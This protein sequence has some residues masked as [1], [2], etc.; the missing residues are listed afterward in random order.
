MKPLGAWRCASSI[1]RTGCR[2][3][4]VVGPIEAEVRWEDG[5]HDKEM[6]GW[7]YEVYGT[8]VSEQEP[9]KTADAA[10]LAAEETLTR[11]IGDAVREGSRL[12]LYGKKR[13][14][15]ELK[16]TRDRK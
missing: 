8:E 1:S 2:Y 11:A 6:E 15:R 13:V 10:K 16:A 4:L 14:V 5:Y 3:F 12:G 9:Y 7:Y